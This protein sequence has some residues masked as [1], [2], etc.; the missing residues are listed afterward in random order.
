MTNTLSLYKASALDDN[1][2]TEKLGC[3]IYT[4]LPDEGSTSTSVFTSFWLIKT[5]FFPLQYFSTLVN[6]FG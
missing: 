1:T 3:F 5:V 2:G 4:V 6:G